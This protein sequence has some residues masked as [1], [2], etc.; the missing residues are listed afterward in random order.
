M[1]FVSTRSYNKKLSW[2]KF[3]IVPMLADFQVGNI[4]Y[5]RNNKILQTFIYNSLYSMYLHVYSVD[6][7]TAFAMSYL[8][9]NYHGDCSAMG[10]PTSKARLLSADY[11]L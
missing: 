10:A 5:N 4:C 7:Q 6:R 1:S 2:N 3:F 9:V 11:K 8:F